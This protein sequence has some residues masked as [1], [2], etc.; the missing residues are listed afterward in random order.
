MIYVVFL[1]TLMVSNPQYHSCQIQDHGPGVPTPV[2]QSID[3]C[4]RE[5]GRFNALVG[6]PKGDVYAKAVCMGKPGWQPV[7]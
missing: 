5:A 3:D 4:K 2:Y 7:Q 6:K 1:C